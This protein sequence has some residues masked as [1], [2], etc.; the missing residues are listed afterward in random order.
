MACTT[1]MCA[2]CGGPL[3]ALDKDALKEDVFKVLEVADARKDAPNANICRKAL[4][5]K[6]GSKRTR[7]C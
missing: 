6:F 3:P 7:D 4:K 5:A 1:R 2:R